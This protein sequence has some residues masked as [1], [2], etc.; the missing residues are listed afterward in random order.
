[1]HLALAPSCREEAQ[2]SHPLLWAG[3][4]EGWGF[5]HC[6]CWSGGD[7]EVTL[8]GVL[9]T[10]EGADRGKETAEA[11]GRR[12]SWDSDTLD[13]SQDA[14]RHPEPP[15]H[16]PPLCPRVPPRS[17]KNTSVISVPCLCRESG[18]LQARTPCHGVDVLG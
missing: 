10:Q 3:E 12:Q 11:V 14:P 7:G 16:P 9:G 17:F 1:M 18:M 2:I 6:C 5:H 4:Q 8:A 13:S 15:P